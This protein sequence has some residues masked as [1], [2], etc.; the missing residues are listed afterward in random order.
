MI[1]NLGE[2]RFVQPT[3]DVTYRYVVNFF[4]LL[5]L[6][7]PPYT[8]RQGGFYSFVWEII[9]VQSIVYFKYYLLSVQFV[10]RLNGNVLY[11]FLFIQ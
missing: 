2:V 3:I 8:F 5:Y 1:Y 10:F 6:D 7:M 9:R 11:F 4:N